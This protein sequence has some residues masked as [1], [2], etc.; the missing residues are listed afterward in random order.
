MGKFGSFQSALLHHQPYSCYY[1]IVSSTELVPVDNMDSQQVLDA[2]QFQPSIETQANNQH[3][4]DDQSSQ[5]LTIEEIQ[6]MRDKNIKGE[7][8]AGA[9]IKKIVENS[10]TFEQKT[11]FAKA[12]Y[13]KRKV[14][15]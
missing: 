10:V 2:F 11:E 4:V 14:K 12:K 7:M 8:D 1:H 5:K 6:E 3:I 15:K 9:V 13:I